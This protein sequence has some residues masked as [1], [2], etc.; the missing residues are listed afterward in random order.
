MFVTGLNEW[1]RHETWPPKAA[2]AQDAAPGRRRLARLAGAG[3]AD[4]FDEYVSDPNKPVPLVGYTAQNM[5]SDYM[6]ADQRFA[7]AAPRRA[8]VSDAAARPKT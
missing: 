3:A 8:G 2:Q 5:P 6:T 7:G 4:G 1:R